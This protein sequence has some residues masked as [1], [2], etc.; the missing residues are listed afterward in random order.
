MRKP[1]VFGFVMCLFLSFLLL[2]PANAQGAGVNEAYTKVLA[3]WKSACNKAKSEGDTDGDFSFDFY[4]MSALASVK[5]Y[6]ALYDID[7]NGIPELILKKT[8]SYEDIIAYI[9]T[10][11]DG[12]AL[13]IF[14]YDDRG[15]PGEVP[16]SREGSSAILSNGLID[17]TDGDYTL[18]RMA[19]DGYS[20]TKFAS[21]EPQ[22][23]PDG[24]SLHEAKWKYYANKK[25]VDY[26]AYLRHLKTRG[27][28]VGGENPLASIDWVALH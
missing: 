1:G 26:D 11:K 15:R 28:K 17:C 24:A 13:N 7:G 18:Y 5:A 9:F 3:E 16:W 21:R 22:D 23:S 19:D 20:V 12:K 6:Y 4:D 27:Y 10:I 25:Q 8:T 2:A 14:G